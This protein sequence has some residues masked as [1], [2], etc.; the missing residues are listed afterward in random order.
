M[1]VAV[2]GSGSVEGDRTDLGQLLEWKEDNVM[3]IRISLGV[4]VVV[5]SL[6]MAGVV[7]GAGVV[8]LRAVGSR[9]LE[10]GR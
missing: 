6:R 3:H 1:R 8:D 9:S 5:G 4:G 7:S 2:K 10:R